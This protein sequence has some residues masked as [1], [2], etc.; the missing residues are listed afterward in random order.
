MEFTKGEREITHVKLKE[1]FFVLFFLVFFFSVFSVHA[2]YYQ[3]VRI[4][5]YVAT[6]LFSFVYLP[7]FLV[8]GALFRVFRYIFHGTVIHNRRLFFPRDLRV[9]L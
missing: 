7:S 5:L 4:I 8:L 9:A 3:Y 1:S 6:I 2:I